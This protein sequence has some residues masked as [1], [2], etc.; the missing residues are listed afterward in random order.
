LKRRCQLPFA[1]GG[2]AFFLTIDGR[3]NHLFVRRSF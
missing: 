2:Q 3:H 1:D